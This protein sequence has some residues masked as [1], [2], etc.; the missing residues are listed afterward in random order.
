MN[1]SKQ[2]A[3][4]EPECVGCRQQLSESEFEHYEN[5][6]NQERLCVRCFKESRAR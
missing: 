3:G 1:Q 5:H 4:H 6:P 2:A